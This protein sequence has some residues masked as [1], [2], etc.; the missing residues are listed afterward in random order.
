MACFDEG[1]TPACGRRGYF[2]VPLRGLSG[3]TGAVANGGKNAGFFPISETKELQ[4]NGQKQRK[5]QV[6]NQAGR[7]GR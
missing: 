4:T 6:R 1:L 5:K 2:S 3:C 7:P